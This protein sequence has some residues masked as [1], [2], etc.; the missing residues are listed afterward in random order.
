MIFSPTSQHALRALIY[1]AQ[2]GAD[3]PVRVQ[4][5]AASEGIPRQF[6]SKILHSLRNQGLVVATKGPGG[7]YALA[8]APERVT[9]TDVVSAVDG[10]LDLERQCILGLSRCHDE[11]ACALHEPWKK[12]RGRFIGTIGAM[13]LAQAAGIIR[14][15]A[16]QK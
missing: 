2:H 15:K 5:I 6:L 13:T 12:L 3:G 14:R 4:Q 8:K 11:S 9:V 16:K 7:G 10:E 1:L